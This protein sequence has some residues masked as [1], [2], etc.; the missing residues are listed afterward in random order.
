MT[1]IHWENSNLV[2]A[3]IWTWS[4]LNRTVRISHT[5]DLVFDCSQWGFFCSVHEKTVKMC[6][7]QAHSWCSRD[8]KVNSLQEKYG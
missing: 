2:L 3:E 4:Y 8:V 1:V 6:L 7:T 5:F